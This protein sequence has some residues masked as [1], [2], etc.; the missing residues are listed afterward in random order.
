MDLDIIL[1]TDVPESQIIF[2][3][4]SVEMRMVEK[5]VND[6][7]LCVQQRSEIIYALYRF[8]QL[9]S[10]YLEMWR[11]CQGSPEQQV[12]SNR[13][14]KQIDFNL[15]RDARSCF[16]NGNFFGKIRF[17]LHACQKLAVSELHIRKYLEWL[18]NFPIVPEQSLKGILKH[19]LYPSNLPHV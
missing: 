18:L 16:S 11:K 2:A 13:I 19:E 4:T 8:K 3:L 5:I 17:L 12:V 9:Y 10:H 7:N 6:F 14:F 1:G 15:N